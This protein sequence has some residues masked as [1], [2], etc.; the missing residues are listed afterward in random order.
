[1]LKKEGFIMSV[2]N[3]KKFLDLAKS[4]EKL[5]KELI[6]INKK[7]QKQEGNEEKF[8]ADNIVPLAKKNGVIFTAKDFL[9]YAD[10]QMSTLSEEDLLNVSGGANAKRT[11]MAWL[12]AGITAASFAA[13]A[14]QQFFSEQPTSSAFAGSNKS[15]EENSRNNQDN[16]KSDANRDIDENSKTR[17]KANVEKNKVEKV[18][19]NDKEGPKASKAEQKNHKNKNRVL[20]TNSNAKNTPAVPQINV[21]P[22]K[23]NN[24]KKSA[25][26]STP[27][28]APGGVGPTKHAKNVGGHGVA[29]ADLKGKAAKP[30][31]KTT[32]NHEGN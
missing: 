4:N 10:E 20:P 15:S 8:I 3:V 5:Q 16:A 26:K 25:K 19:K 27:T 21:A 11:A 24:A 1:M 17:R 18:A 2:K 29:V 12:F 6:L 30:A 28:V 22:S 31:S 13:P 14:V 7:L 9:K 23:T 32:D